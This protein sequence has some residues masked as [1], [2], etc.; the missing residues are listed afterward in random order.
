MAK[1]QLPKDS[2][3]LM[4][5]PAYKHLMEREDKLKSKG[6]N[7]QVPAIEFMSA[8]ELKKRD[9]TELYEAIQN[10]FLDM[11]NIPWY[12]LSPLGEEKINLAVVFSIEHCKEDG[13]LEQFY[14]QRP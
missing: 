14:S 12:A 9:D 7:S 8:V 4:S 6:I 3:I 5:I 13:G 1:K 11:Y 10:L 2:D